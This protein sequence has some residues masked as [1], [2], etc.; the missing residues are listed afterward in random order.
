MSMEDESE[1]S[2]SW[3]QNPLTKLLSAFWEQKKAIWPSHATKI[4]GESGFKI[5]LSNTEL[6]LSNLKNKVG[7]GMLAGTVIQHTVS[8]LS[9]S[10][11]PLLHCISWKDNL[12]N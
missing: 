9:I 12:S 5:L 1:E 8:I 10:F 3:P 11:I 7:L 6:L 4:S 2:L